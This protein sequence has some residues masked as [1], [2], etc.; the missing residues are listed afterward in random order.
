V[1]FCGPVPPNPAD[2]LSSEYMRAL[3]REGSKEYKFVVLDSPPLLNLADSRI[4]A[5]LVDGVILV[6]GGGSTPRDLVQRAYM[7]AV[8]AGSRVL[9]ATINFA[10]VKNDYYYSEYRQP[11]SGES[12][13]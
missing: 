2:L 9:G 8:D 11:E 5:T 13:K 4:L 12:E 3:I 7:S 1:L 10:D 6:V